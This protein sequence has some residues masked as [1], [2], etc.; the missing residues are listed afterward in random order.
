M[1]LP[2]KNMK[3][4]NNKPRSANSYF[5]CT[6]P[7]P[8]GN[9]SL[10]A[11]NLSF[12]SLSIHRSIDVRRSVRRAR[13]RY[14]QL[15]THGKF[16]DSPAFNELWRLVKEE[17]EAEA[18]DMKNNCASGY[19]LKKTV[20]REPDWDDDAGAGGTAANVSAWRAKSHARSTHTHTH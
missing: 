11:I 10:E 5:F 12:S 15:K 2:N 1:G 6:R 3:T 20:K 16:E 4:Y 9:V 13:I 14:L 19:T 17:A 18:V 7:M 8:Y